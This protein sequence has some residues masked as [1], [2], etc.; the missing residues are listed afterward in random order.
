MAQQLLNITKGLQKSLLQLE[1]ILN[2][3]I[4]SKTPCVSVACQVVLVVKNSLANAGDAKDGEEL[5]PW[6]G[7]IP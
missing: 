1:T 7:K 2:T 5:D 3:V 4:F 6:V